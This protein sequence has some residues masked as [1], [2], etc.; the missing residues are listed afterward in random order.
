[1]KKALIL[2]IAALVVPSAALAAK[3]PQAGKSAPTVMY[4]LK[5]KLSA[6]TA[7][8]ASTKTNGSITITVSSSNHHGKELKGQSLTFAVTADTAVVLHNGAPIANGDRGIVKIRAAKRI[9]ADG[10]AK[11]LPQSSAKQVI[12]L[13]A[14]VS[15]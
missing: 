5:G 15:H 9:A 12:D 11:T 2:V 4:V 6:Y 13:G 7:Y 10:F 1:M 3:P 14:K 8:D